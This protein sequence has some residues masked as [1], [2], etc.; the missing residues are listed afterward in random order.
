MRNYIFKQFFSVIKTQSHLLI[1]NRSLRPNPHRQASSKI[2][3]LIH[4]RRDQKTFS[5]NLFWSNFAPKFA[6]R[7]NAPGFADCIKTPDFTV[8]PENFMTYLSRV[9]HFIFIRCSHHS[10]NKIDEIKSAKQHNA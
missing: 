10:K 5:K 2:W 4:L 7:S 8:S 1:E 9:L 3:Y 6:S